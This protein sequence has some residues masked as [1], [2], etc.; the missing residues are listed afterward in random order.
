M[1]LLGTLKVCGEET[2]KWEK[3]ER[4]G[5]E[6][7]S[8]NFSPCELK[9]FL[10]C[11]GTYLSIILKNFT[12]ERIILVMRKNLEVKKKSHYLLEFCRE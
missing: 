10:D 12:G 3:N 11:S 7:E 6:E 2:L 4:S 1:L 8:T 9:I 5:T